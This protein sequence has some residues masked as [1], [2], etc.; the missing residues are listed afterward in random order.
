MLNNIISTHIISNQI[1]SIRALMLNHELKHTVNAP[2]VFSVGMFSRPEETVVD[3]FCQE[4]VIILNSSDLHKTSEC[5]IK[6]VVAVVGMNRSFVLIPIRA[7]RIRIAAP[8]RDV[9]VSRLWYV[10]A[11]AR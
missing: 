1:I 5:N 7:I 10:I 9:V 6:R 2:N 8:S 4:V 11:F 3:L